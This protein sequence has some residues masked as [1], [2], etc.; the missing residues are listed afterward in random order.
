[1]NSLLV[2]TVKNPCVLLS[3]K[4]L[5]DVQFK[6]FLHD[7]PAVY[8]GLTTRKL[9]METRNIPSCE[10]ANQLLSLGYMCAVLPWL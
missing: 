8:F 1:M 10:N 4:K 7:K 6:N 5:V 9:K 3:F 2:L